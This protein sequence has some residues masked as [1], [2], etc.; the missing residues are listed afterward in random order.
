EY[1]AITIHLPDRSVLVIERRGDGKILAKAAGGKNSAVADFW[2]VN[3]HR[4][5]VAMAEKFGSLDQPMATGNLH[6][7]NVDGSG[8]RLLIGTEPQEDSTPSSETDLFGKE[9]QYA[10][11]IDTLPKEDDFVLVGISTWTSDPIT[12]V[13]RMNVDNGRLTD[14]ATAPLNR[15]DFVTDALG[16]VRFA[17]GLD[18]ENYS[19]LLYRDNDKAPWQTINDERAS[20]HWE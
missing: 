9:Y 12:R 7:M 19:K 17:I 14:V 2:W 6:G 4:V 15:A 11:M 1:Y 16:Q 20:G 13:A 10:E 3:D 5:M 8:A 18:K